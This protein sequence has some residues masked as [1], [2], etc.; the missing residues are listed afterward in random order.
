MKDLDFETGWTSWTGTRFR[1]PLSSADNGGAMS[2]VDAFQPAGSGPARHIHHDAAGTFVRGPGKAIVVPRGKEQPF[3]VIGEG[4][5]HHQTFMGP[6][7][8]M[9]A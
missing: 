9:E 2:I 6:A 3:P 5:G 1:V 4:E 7:L 8:E